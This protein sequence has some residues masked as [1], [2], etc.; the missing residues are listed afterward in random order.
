VVAR[1]TRRF[2]INTLEAHLS[3]IQL[4]DE[5]LEN[6]HRVLFTDVVI[7]ALGQ[8]TTLCPV[9]ALDTNRFIASASCRELP[10]LIMSVRFY[11]AS[12]VRLH[13]GRHR[14]PPASPQ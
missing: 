8:Q 1:P 12:A 14:V 4:V 10:Y 7:D 3:K 11:T 6:P 13:G 5:S 9:H 2:W